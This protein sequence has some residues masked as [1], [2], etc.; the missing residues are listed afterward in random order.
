MF[1]AMIDIETLSTSPNALVLTI[2]AIIFNPRDEPIPLKN[3]KTFYKRIDIES[4][5]VLK[6]DVDKNTLEWWKDQPKES[7]YEAIENTDREHVKSVLLSLSDFIKDCNCIWAN[8]P[9]FDC[10]I[11]ENVYKKLGLEIPWKFWNLRDTRT[12]YAIANLKLRNFSD[13]NVSHHALEDCYSQIK[14]L[15]ASLRKLNNII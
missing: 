10:V 9:N 6:L 12:V 1:D 15:N 14:C 5:K 7:R 13:K 8:S 11:L 4:C 3:M 2:G